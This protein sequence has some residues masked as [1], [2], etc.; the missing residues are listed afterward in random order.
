MK[1]KDLLGFHKGLLSASKFSGV[2]FAYAVARNLSK[3]SEEMEALQKAQMPSD[4]FL[5]YDK[6]RVELV[7]KY[8]ERDTQGNPVVVNNQ[9][10]ILS[11]KKMEFEAKG[12]ELEASHKDVLDAYKAHQKEFDALLEGSCEFNLVKVKSEVLPEDIT[13]ETLSLILPM[14]EEE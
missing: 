14:I 6:E 3:I 9:Y 1:R 11:K 13:G 10:T 7:L 12:A 4:A 2:K 5:K 8:A